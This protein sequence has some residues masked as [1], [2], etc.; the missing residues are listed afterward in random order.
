MNKFLLFMFNFFLIN[1]CFSL[2]C[3]YLVE[4]YGDYWLADEGKGLIKRLTFDGKT[5]NSSAFWSLDGSIIAD[6]PSR[7]YNEQTQVLF[8]NNEGE[9]LLKYDTY[10]GPKTDDF[11]RGIDKIGWIDKGRVYL[12]IEV[13]PNGGVIEIVDLDFEK[14]Q[15]RTF[16]CISYSGC[17]CSL[18]KERF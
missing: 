18:S 1:F 4:T 16:K 12:D 7:A 14:N 8:L 2:D 15:A 17:C 10:I 9:E 11:V 3:K 6:S 5:K 13:G